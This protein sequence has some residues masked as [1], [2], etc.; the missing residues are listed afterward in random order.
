MRQRLDEIKQQTKE[1]QEDRR[2]QLS[3]LNAQM[4][5][6]LGTLTPSHP[7]AIGLRRKI[8]AL[9]DELPSVTALKNEERGILNELAAMTGSKDGS[10]GNPALESDK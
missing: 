9:S 8:E 6:I 5:G 10:N 4:A 7:T 3:E 1:L 2:R